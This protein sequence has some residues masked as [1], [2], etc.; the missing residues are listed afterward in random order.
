[1]SGT[2]PS[3]CDDA[4][5]S[6][7]SAPRSKSDREQ[8]VKHSF[9]LDA[10]H[11]RCIVAANPNTPMD[12]LAHLAEDSANLVR[13]HVAENPRTSQAVLKRL[14][15][16]H[17]AEVRLA[18]AENSCTSPELLARLDSDA[19]VRYG[20][21]ENPHMPMNILADLARDDNPYIRFRALKTLK[22]LSPE[23]QAKLDLT[24]GFFFS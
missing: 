5:S 9:D 20:V 1:M 17:E 24:R 13:R 15:Y 7:Y 10:L 23:L 14:A 2:E 11:I 8:S 3:G 18:V 21:A 19:D 6:T 16:D 4:A 12:V 22:N